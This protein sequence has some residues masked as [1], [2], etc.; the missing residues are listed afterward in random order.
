MG[1]V[2]DNAAAACRIGETA[3]DKGFPKAALLL[4]AAGS[5]A[6]APVPVSLFVEE[7]DGCTRVDTGA[8]ESLVTKQRKSGSGG[9][10]NKRRSSTRG[11]GVKRGV[12]VLR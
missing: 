5:T 6:R 10:G 8:C 7:A 9:K 12:E 1:D 11:A 2:G 4:K 3:G